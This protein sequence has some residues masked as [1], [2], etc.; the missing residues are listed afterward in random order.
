MMIKLH[1]V[2]FL[3]DLLMFVITVGLL[4][5]LSENNM[6]LWFAIAFIFCSALFGIMRFL[7]WGPIKKM[8]EDEK[9]KN[10][11]FTT[12]LKKARIEDFYNMQYSTEQ[13]LRNERTKSIISNGKTFNL[14]SMTAA[15]YLDPSVKRHWDYLSKAIENGCQLNIII[16][17]PLCYEKEIR[18]KINKIGSPWDSKLDFK[19][20]IDL[21]NKYQNINIKIYSNNIYCA[22][23][24]SE[25]EMI[26]DPY[27]LGKVS[28][29]IENYFISFH[30]KNEPHED[31][32]F[33][34][35]DILKKHFEYLWINSE[36][37]EMYI[38]KNMQNV[39]YGDLKE[40]RVQSRFS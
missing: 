19:R 18:N 31:G 13:N 23:L 20:L 22:L 14:L 32:S 21:Y 30:Y 33:S 5:F 7:E 9:E 11:Y 12:K 1:K 3:L 40:V 25:T 38:N 34:Y 39:I 17:D 15:S 28:D 10:F 36:S 4:T 8:L 29:R 2:K 37:F 6:W 16:M 35:Y 27:H 24:F 26:Y